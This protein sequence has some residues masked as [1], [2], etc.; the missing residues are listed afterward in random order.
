MTVR[1]DNSPHR[2]VIHTGLLYFNHDAARVLIA[3]DTEAA[4]ITGRWRL[5]SLKLSRT[6]SALVF[7]AATSGPSSHMREKRTS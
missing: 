3:Y 4:G 2:L 6:L 1:V 5:E 7:H